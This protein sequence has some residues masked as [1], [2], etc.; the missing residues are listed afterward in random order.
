MEE[1]LSA[2]KMHFRYLWLLPGYE[3]AIPKING[4]VLAELSNRRKNLFYR[5]I[6][7]EKA[8]EAEVVRV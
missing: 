6:R 5:M 2:Q 8:G 4:R 3:A 7:L 1:V